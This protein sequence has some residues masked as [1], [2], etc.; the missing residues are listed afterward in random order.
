MQCPSHATTNIGYA[1]K[2]FNIFAMFWMLLVLLL[3]LLWSILPK[4]MS[5]FYL[6]YI[7]DIYVYMMK[8]YMFCKITNNNILKQ[9]AEVWSKNG[10]DKLTAKYTLMTIPLLFMEGGP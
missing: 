9:N 4:Y 5:L 8:K 10:T 2:L 1:Y 6:R 3:L 7:L